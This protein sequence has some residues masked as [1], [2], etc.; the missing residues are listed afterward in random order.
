MSSPS[1]PPTTFPDAHL[2]NLQFG[3]PAAGYANVL[4]Q[5]TTEPGKYCL[6]FCACQTLFRISLFFFFSFYL[7]SNH[8]FCFFCHDNLLLFLKFYN[9]GFTHIFCFPFF[10]ILAWDV[11]LRVYYKTL[12]SKAA[13]KSLW[14]GKPTLVLYIGLIQPL[15][16]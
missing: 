15:F 2:L 12:L 1:S 7:L 9:K 11:I 10:T 13:A 5:M 4:D 8:C 3:H 14:S 6:L 16:L